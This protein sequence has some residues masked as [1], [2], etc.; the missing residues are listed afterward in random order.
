[1]LV[2]GDDG[3]ALAPGDADRLDLG[4]E[5]SAPA[6][7]LAAPLGL[8]RVEVRGLARHAGL[9]G[10]LFGGLAHDEAG[11]RIVE[12]VLVHA[13]DDLVAAEPIAPARP[14]EQVG[15]VRHALGAAGEN[16]L[17]LAE[18]DRAGGGDH[19]LQ[20][21]AAGLVDRECRTLDRDPGAEGDLA[22]AVRSAVGLAAVPED[23][24][25]DDP[26][27]VSGDPGST[28]TGLGGVRAE[29]GRGKSGE[30]AAEL[31]DRSPHRSDQRQPLRRPAPRARE[32]VRH[33]LA[34]NCGVRFST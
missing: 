8:D 17:R 18:E 14:G 9:D 7:G 23:H 5:A 15:R 16:D 4:D 19:R 33:H 10:Q 27:R 25:I 29:V 21:R 28:Q 24:L 1:M 34:V 13:V 26:R 31:S 3:L 2:G 6:R 22:G 30:A 32:P 11:E 20:A 12:A